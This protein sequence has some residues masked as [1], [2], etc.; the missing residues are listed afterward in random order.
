[1]LKKGIV[2][3]A[4]LVFLSFVLVSL[5]AFALVEGRRAFVNNQ[6]EDRIYS[7]YASLDLDDTKYR[8]FDTNIFGDKR[9][10]SWDKNRTKSSSIALGTNQT[11]QKVT[12]E[13]KQH[14][15]KAGF[16]PAGDAYVDSVNPEYYFKNKRGEYIRLRVATKAVQD[17]MMYGTPDLARETIDRNKAPSYIIINVNLDDNNE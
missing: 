3:Y 4:A 11:P 2:V 12:E 9:V 14:I 5:S 13:L 17:S 15:T 16:E 8:V 6:R 10:Y 7:I 1:M